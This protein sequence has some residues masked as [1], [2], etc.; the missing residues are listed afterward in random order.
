MR[1]LGSNSG[2]RTTRLAG[3]MKSHAK[4]CDASANGVW[5]ARECSTAEMT[6]MG[7]SFPP[8]TRFATRVPWRFCCAGGCAPVEDTAC[9]S[10]VEKSAAGWTGA[11]LGN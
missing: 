11:V 5:Q 7:L 6:A 2:S 3:L 10:G 9:S 1:G 8:S 4:A